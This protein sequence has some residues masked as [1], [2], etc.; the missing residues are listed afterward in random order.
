MIYYC[1]SE[2]KFVIPVIIQSL[3]FLKVS[4]GSIGKSSELAF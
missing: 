2:S 4:A 1:L 3:T